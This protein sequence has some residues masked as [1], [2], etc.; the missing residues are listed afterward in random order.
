MKTLRPR[1]KWTLTAL[2][3]GLPSCSV[4]GAGAKASAQIAR[5]R[6]SLL[7]FIAHGHRIPENFQKVFHHPIRTKVEHETT[8]NGSIAVKTF[9]YRGI[10]IVT[11]G[12]IASIDISSA[13]Y[14]TDGGIVIGS[15]PI[16]N[17]MALF[18]EPTPSDLVREQCGRRA[19]GDVYKSFAYVTS[20]EAGGYDC[21]RFDFG[22][23]ERINRIQWFYFID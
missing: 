13:G 10:T 14:A 11:M 18:G 17:V 9:Y 15:S 22:A 16:R 3:V 12:G 5:N 23:S 21:V 8:P 6:V 19:V 20:S 4:F 7:E 2:I 1:L